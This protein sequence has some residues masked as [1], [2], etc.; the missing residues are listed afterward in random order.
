[1]ADIEVIGQKRYSHQDRVCLLYALIL[2]LEGIELYVEQV[3]DFTLKVKDESVKATLYFQ[4]KDEKPEVDLDR[5]CQCLLH[6]NKDGQ[7]LAGLLAN[8]N[9]SK[10]VFVV[11]SRLKDEVSG[12]AL[13]DVGQCVHKVSNLK[14]SERSGL[15]DRLRSHE[16]KK[17]S[18]GETQQKALEDFEKSEAIQRVLVVERQTETKTRDQLDGILRRK[19]FVPPSQTSAIVEQL[20]AE[21][22][23][24][25]KS[26]GEDAVPKLKSILNPFRP[27]QIFPE[28]SSFIRSREEELKA[29]LKASKVLLLTGPSGCGK[30]WLA[31]FIAQSLQAEGYV[32]KET[33]ELKEGLDF[34][35]HAEGQDR[36]S[37]LSDPFGFEPS[38]L[39]PTVAN[40]TTQELLRYMI[41][42][43]AGL[44]IVTSPIQM[45]NVYNLQLAGGLTLESWVNVDLP[46]DKKIEI[47]QSLVS[48]HACPRHLA[49]AFEELLK[50][51][52]PPQ[53][54]NYLQLVRWCSENPSATRSEMEEVARQSARAQ[55]ETV[56]SSFPETRRALQVLYLTTDSVTGPIKTPPSQEFS[57]LTPDSL[58]R[59]ENRLLIEVRNGIYVFRHPDFQKAAVVSFSGLGENAW[60]ASQAVIEDRVVNNPLAGRR[61]HGYRCLESIFA[62]LDQHEQRRQDLFALI[63]PEFQKPSAPPDPKE[64]PE[65]SPL[66][67]LIRK[68]APPLRLDPAI[69]DIVLRLASRYHNTFGED[70]VKRVLE[71][72]DQVGIFR[73]RL[74]WNDGAVTYDLSGGHDSWVLQGEERGPVADSL[75]EEQLWQAVS[76]PGTLHRELALQAGMSTLGSVRAVAALK[77][78]SVATGQVADVALNFLQDPNPLV[79]ARAIQG[80]LLGWSA[81]EQSQREEYFQAA[82]QQLGQ[83]FHSHVLIKVVIH[84]RNLA[85][86]DPEWYHGWTFPWSPVGRLVTVALR[87]VPPHSHFNFYRIDNFIQGLSEAQLPEILAELLRA[88]AG[89]NIRKARSG[90]GLE[91][92]SPACQRFLFTSFASQPGLLR[93]P[94]REFLRIP[95]LESLCA[96]MGFAA[97]EW[98][99]IPPGS[100]AD[101][102]AFAKIDD[103]KFDL[104]R[105]AVTMSHPFGGLAQSLYGFATADEAMER[106]PDGVLLYCLHIISGCGL[107]SEPGR[108][109]FDWRF[110]SG[111]VKSVLKRRP[112][113][114]RLELACNSL[115]H[116][117]DFSGR[118]RLKRWKQICKQALGKDLF[119]LV[120]SFQWV[121]S[122]GPVRVKDYW[123]PLRGRLEQEPLAEG[124][125]AILAR[126]FVKYSD[127]IGGFDNESILFEM[128]PISVFVLELLPRDVA[129]TK[130]LM[131]SKEEA[132]SI[133]S[134]QTALERV[135]SAGPPC[136]SKIRE[137]CFQRVGSDFAKTLVSYIPD[138][139]EDNPPIQKLGR[140]EDPW[141]Y[142]LEPFFQHSEID[143][144]L[145]K[146]WGSY[147]VTIG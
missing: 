94:L 104:V 7:P 117:G 55:V 101:L 4:V 14:S 45:L 131:K 25:V 121:L 103:P 114:I 84:F 110:A 77:Y 48:R 113:G 54:L 143:T 144:T 44:L 27:G 6:F 74:A 92:D 3:E 16:P 137:A 100:Q 40:R 21:A 134:T 33:S 79:F 18:R 30:T 123:P 118:G 109:S 56:L 138:F 129:A 73:E 98:E 58:D 50:R 2:G 19:F 65:E 64:Q 141:A 12:L 132:W 130:V 119:Y 29:Q 125:V 116:L 26:S 52:D 42:P 76:A 90:L 80:L 87:E 37:I 78:L 36:V 140:E 86:W 122:N 96:L 69:E 22:I 23:V 81:L 99:K 83:P 108:W 24:P 31:R 46:M 70:L 66:K 111:L 32:P 126:L 34:L 88:L 28:A 139:S 105:A 8:D 38:N 71:G 60:R 9:Q 136:L 17:E 120:R 43:A 93:E 107:R 10:A 61:Q 1:M 128:G 53:P 11:S 146:F 127:K 112:S 135:F 97:T 5:I 75:D 115:A 62:L 145:E 59:L 91:K 39:D 72:L 67:H 63:L 15:H 142:W 13:A 41:Q 95:T 102:L 68:F 147:G 85:G 47:W 49:Q 35:R 20:C 106:L 89:R 82:V 57:D 133:E 51:P 124:E